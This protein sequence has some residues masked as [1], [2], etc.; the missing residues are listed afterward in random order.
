MALSGTSRP[1]AYNPT[2]SPISGTTEF[3]EFVLG[4]VDVDYSSDYGGL[5]WW[6][7]PIES[8]IGRAH[9]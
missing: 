5:K 3:G 6:G 4:D 8:E 2:A 1:F 7:G 9:V